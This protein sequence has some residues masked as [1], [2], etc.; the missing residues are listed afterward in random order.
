MSALALASTDDGRE[1]D[2]DGKDKA[3]ADGDGA[4]SSLRR[5]RRLLAGMHA[6]QTTTKLRQMHQVRPLA[7]G[8]SGLA[9]R[10]TGVEEEGAALLFFHFC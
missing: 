9:W 3:A 5:V 7:R 6:N 10:K 1:K 8:G 2:R 4:E